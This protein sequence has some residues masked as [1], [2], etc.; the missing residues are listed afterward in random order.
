[1]ESF[2]LLI[3]DQLVQSIHYAIENWGV[4]I[5]LGVFVLELLLLAARRQITRNVLGD[6]VANFVTLFLSIVVNT[7]LLAFVYLAAFYVVWIEFSLFQLPT[8]L[9]T[10]LACLVLADLAY[11]WEHRFVHRVGFAWATHAVHHSSPHFN[12]SVAYRFGPLDGL[13]PLPFHLPLALLGFNPLVI[14]FCEMV[15]QL[16]QTLLHTEV[17][18]KLPRPIEALLNTPSHHRVHH[19]SNPQYMDRNYGG[20]LIV[21]D[22]LFGTFAE[23]QEPVKFGITTPIN[24]VNPVKIFLFGYQLLFKK[25]WG[26]KTVADALGY[27]FQPPDWQPQVV[28]NQGK[29]RTSS[30][31]KSKT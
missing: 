7:I 25:M 24:S 31:M 18:K 28:N 10:I 2:Y 11:Y 20:I 21:W 8:N 26:A 17:V 22:K 14:L 16:Y 6:V 5:T 15:V 29:S 27:F 12:I 13:M 23:E 3:S 19:G 4:V 1:M 9:W 30:Q